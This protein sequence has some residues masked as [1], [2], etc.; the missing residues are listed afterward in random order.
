[1]FATHMYGEYVVSGEG[2]MLSAVAV[3]GG[4]SL[5]LIIIIRGLVVADKLSDLRKQ[6]KKMSLARL[7]YR[8]GRCA[9]RGWTQGK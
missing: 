7:L 9:T 1:M 2:V 3:C 4:L 6:A 8:R 5:I